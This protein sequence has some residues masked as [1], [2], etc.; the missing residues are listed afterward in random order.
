M[1]NTFFA[2]LS[3]RATPPDA[4]FLRPP[5]NDPHAK[6]WTYAGMA[7]ESARMA[8]ALVALGVEPGDRV[9]AQIEKSPEG[10]MLYLGTLRAG[11]VFLPRNTSYTAA[12]L[13]YFIGDAEPKVVVCD[14]ARLTAIAEI[15][16]G[17]AVETLDA[18]GR[19]TLSD[20][21]ARQT[22]TISHSLVM[23]IDSSSAMPCSPG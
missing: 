21:A 1:H 5:R 2:S 16:R 11:A 4:L 20:L 15:A 9:A 13:D 12:E 19:G 23:E 17:A 7:A 14:P 8:Q 6:S 10:L 18:A 22:G 3:A